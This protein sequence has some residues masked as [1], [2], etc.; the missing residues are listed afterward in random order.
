MEEMGTQDYIHSFHVIG[1]S[2]AMV[3]VAAAEE[4]SCVVGDTGKGQEQNRAD[5]PTQLS[6]T[7]R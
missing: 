4:G 1:V 5:D 2:P 3:P 6:Y 7:P